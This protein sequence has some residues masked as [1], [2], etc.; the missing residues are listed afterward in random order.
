M[1][2]SKSCET[3]NRTNDIGRDGGDELV[4]IQGSVL[5]MD[6]LFPLQVQELYACYQIKM[7]DVEKTHRC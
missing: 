7:E 6:L 2:A 4:I 1:R 3:Y 5:E